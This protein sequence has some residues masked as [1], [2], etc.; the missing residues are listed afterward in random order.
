[1]GAVPD[2]APPPAEHAVTASA[3][4]Q[5]DGSVL[6]EAAVTTLLRVLGEAPPG[7]PAWVTAR[8]DDAGAIARAEAI[9]SVLARAG[10]NVKK[11]DRTSVPVRQGVFVYAADDEPPAFVRTVHRALGEIGLSPTFATGYRSYYEEMMRTKP[12]YQG[13]ALA[14]DQ[15]FILVF[16]RVR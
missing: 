2:R 12:G 4:V 14:P 6:G 7:S 3:P 10:W 13:F 16:G 1:M 15:S 9:V 5:K 8:A 11:N